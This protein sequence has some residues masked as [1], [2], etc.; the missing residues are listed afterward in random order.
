MTFQNDHENLAQ[1]EMDGYE[2]AAERKKRA[3]RK[4]ATAKNKSNEK[5][6]STSQTPKKSSPRNLLY[7]KVYRRIEGQLMTKKPASGNANKT[8]EFL[9]D[10]RKRAATAGRKAYDDAGL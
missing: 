1:S 3:A 8:I 9:V 10:V 2:D 4:V 6:P 7:S 5:A